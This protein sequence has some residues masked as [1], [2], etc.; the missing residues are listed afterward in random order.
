VRRQ[1]P[2]LALVVLVCTGLVGLALIFQRR[3]QQPD[4]YPAFSTFRTLPEGSSILYDALAQT[5]GIT[6]ERNVR[7]LGTVHFSGA[8][9][10]ILGVSLGGLAANGQ[11]FTDMEDLAAAGNRVI[12][13]FVP[14]RNR[15][16]NNDPK[17]LATTLKRW[18][19]N[20]EFVTQQDP[21]EDADDNL[22][23]G[24]P[25]Y[26]AT[27]VGWNILRKDDGRAVVIERAQ[28]KGSLVLL[29]N[30]YLLSNAAMVDD[31]QTD[32]LASLLGPSER[33]V[34]DETHFGIEQTGSIAGLARRYRLQGFF[35]GV[36]LTAALFIW[37]SAA[38]F[39]PAPAVPARGSVLGEDAGAAFL[40]LLRRNIKSEDILST[41]VESW[42]K[43]NRKNAQYRAAAIELAEA[44]RKT[45]AAAYARI[46]EILSPGAQHT[47]S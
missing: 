45:P 14:H 13:A 1:L 37:K 7:A 22:V 26:F 40:N 31:R 16:L 41:C 27:A 28:G 8:A 15:F 23:A 46:Q 35:L 17:E 43:L 10:L 19:V 9:I 21:R 5:P 24:W 47:K 25:M 36:V 34:F 32:F 20:P 29:G 18:S 39:P 12:I 42:S 4:S 33:A 38:G 11:W 2:R 3:A 44:G 6:A 30:P